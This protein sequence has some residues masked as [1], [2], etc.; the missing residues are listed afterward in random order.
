[1]GPTESQHNEKD[2]ML[3]VWDEGEKRSEA[4]AE[5]HQ[6]EQENAGRHKQKRKQE[7]KELKKS[8]EVQ[9][10]G[11]WS[12][13]EIQWEKMRIKKARAQKRGQRNK[14]DREKDKDK[15][16]DKEQVEE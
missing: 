3:G 2:V 12:K 6:K 13:K 9:L 16:Q 1:M 4:L 8:E 14:R 10:A 7:R 15:D 11:Q 5:Q